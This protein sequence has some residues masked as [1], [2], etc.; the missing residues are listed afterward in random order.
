MPRSHY[1]WPEGRSSHIEEH[2]LAKHRILR[3][4]I[5]DYI[6][7]LTSNPKRE[8]LHLDIIDGFAGGGTYVL[9][10]GGNH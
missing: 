4:Y 8:R 10:N 7:I 5:L 3:E 6:R 2:S 1:E 9:P